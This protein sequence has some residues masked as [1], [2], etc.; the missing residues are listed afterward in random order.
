[1]KKPKE[2]E[3]AYI[4]GYIDGEGCIRY[5]QYSPKISLE[6]CNPYPL[7]FL[8]TV[9]PQS[10]VK[11]Q[12]RLT[13]RGKPVYRLCYNGVNALNILSLVMPYLIEKK[14]QAEKVIQIDQLKKELKEAK[15]RKHK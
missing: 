14:D 4:G 10:V 12:S 1:M 13:K 3:L 6:S 9:F 15:Y 8:A 7:N 11:K 2:T 5:E